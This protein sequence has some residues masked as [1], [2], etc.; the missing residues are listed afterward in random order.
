MMYYDDKDTYIYNSLSDEES[1]DWPR[2]PRVIQKAVCNSSWLSLADIGYYR[3]LSN[4]DL[5]TIHEGHRSCLLYF[6]KQKKPPHQYDLPKIWKHVPFIMGS[7]LDAYIL[8]PTQAYLQV[9]LK[10]R[11]RFCL[12][13]N[14]PNDDNLEQSRSSFHS[15]A[16]DTDVLT[17]STQTK[18]AQ[19]LGAP[20]QS[21]QITPIV[22]V[23]Y[24][25]QAKK[26]Y[27]LT[28]KE[29]DE[30]LALE[31]TVDKPRK[32]LHDILQS[33]RDENLTQEQHQQRREHRVKTL[34]ALKALTD[35]DAD[36][37]VEVIHLLHTHKWGYLH[38]KLRSTFQYVFDHNE[39][40]VSPQVIAKR[41]G[42]ELKQ[43]GNGTLDIQLLTGDVDG[44][45]NKWA[46][47]INAL[48]NPTLFS[49]PSFLIDTHT[50]VMRYALGASVT[51]SYSP[52]SHAF[53]FHA[54][55][56]DTLTLFDGT[57]RTQTYF[58]GKNEGKDFSFA[59]DAGNQLDLGLFQTL[60]ELDLHA[61]SGA[62]VELSAALS[63]DL[64]ADKTITKGT[65]IA[66][67]TE[68][69]FAGAKLG[70]DVLGELRW[71][72][73]ESLPPPTDQHKRHEAN[74]TKGDLTKAPLQRLAKVGGGL[75][76]A[77]GVGE[78]EFFK[79]T[80]HDQKFY[81]ICNIQAVA[82]FG[83]MGRF[84]VTIDA[85]T[86]EHFVQFIYHQIKNHNYH[87]TALFKDAAYDAW[88]GIMTVVVWAGESL[89]SYAEQ[90]LST[91]RKWF[92][93]FEA[94]ESNEAARQRQ[95]I[96]NILAKED[97]VKFA[98]PETKGHWLYILSQHPMFSKTYWQY[99][100]WHR[101]RAIHLIL[102]YIQSE[103]E[104]HTALKNMA[105]LTPQNLGQRPR[106]ISVQQ[107]HEMLW[108]A[109]SS[110]V[111]IGTEL[112]LAYNELV[113]D[114]DETLKAKARAY[115]AQAQYRAVAY[116]ALQV[117]RMPA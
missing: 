61:F 31:K 20:Q 93:D 38:K 102:S 46:K 35:N 116:K 27:A 14:S 83:L 64:A 30:T 94:R 49:N 17:T 10:R 12:Y 106:K 77:A 108:N 92:H 55:T 29:L 90:G 24:D 6:E 53:T 4:I 44:S 105:P 67:E 78:G 52:F 43:K 79:I 57:L 18:K 48:P 50:R 2:L 76:A 58:P 42:A 63:F 109:T 1:F 3:P 107:G 28:Q 115:Y 59:D 51:G 40:V 54:D 98:P 85:E 101:Q 25:T 60:F 97:L 110:V 81:I 39:I 62:S 72:N 103:K 87:Y 23:L 75:D 100:V 82:L 34:E 80:Y 96:K 70:S 113:H 36:N 16:T 69:F 13:H 114:L 9:L 73:P 21:E 111:Y 11:N 99:D 32:A 84:C 66:G 7:S 15:H 22:E 47:T 88:V 65:T 26:F 8:K 74:T 104:Y 33:T 56:E 45:F 117:L 5:G 19:S 41:L 86:I 68:S 112:R 89:V 91:A 95:L 37:L 71:A